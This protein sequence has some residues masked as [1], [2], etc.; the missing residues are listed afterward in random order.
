LRRPAAAR[1]SLGLDQPFAWPEAIWAVLG[2][3][4]LLAL[5]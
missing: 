4:V 1:V 2:G 3:G 5:E